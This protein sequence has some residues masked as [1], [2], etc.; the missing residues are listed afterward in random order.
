MIRNHTIRNRDPR[1]FNIFLVLFFLFF[2]LWTAELLNF[3]LK[4]GFLIKNCIYGQLEMSRIL[5]FDPKIRKFKTLAPK[6]T[7]S[8]HTSP[9]YKNLNDLK[10]LVKK[11]GSPGE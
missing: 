8:Y 6:N 4:I 10:I 9:P 7:I 2:G 11:M 5:N 3:N 1:F